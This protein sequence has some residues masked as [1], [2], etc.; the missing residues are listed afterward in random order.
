MANGDSVFLGVVSHAKSHFADAQGPDGL[1]AHLSHEL[2]KLGSFTIVQ[3]NSL[4]YF[5][6]SPFDLTARMARDSVRAEIQLEAEWR[7]YLHG[8]S[9]VRQLARIAGRYFKFHVDWRGHSATT[10]LRRLLNIE[11][12]HVDLYRS[13]VASG[14]KW[15]MIFEDDAFASNSTDLAKGLMRLIE[16]DT[17]VQMV[18]LS[19]SFSLAEI[20]VQ[21]LLTVSTSKQWVGSS[22][23]VV[24]QS[25]R[26]VTNTVCAVAFRTD[27]LALILADFDS[28]PTQPVLPIDWKLNA[29]LMRLWNSGAIK[30]N[31]CWFVEPAPILQLSMVHDRAGD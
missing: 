18:N 14:A 25:E 24:Y 22:A 21:H 29:T 9:R 12:S 31:E 5:D 19:A 4:N 11:Y 15:A 26:P 2:Q 27:F 7:S 8:P 20:G 3:V 30:E 13:A 1:A 6:Q 28:Q 23:R 17:S 10:A 16:S